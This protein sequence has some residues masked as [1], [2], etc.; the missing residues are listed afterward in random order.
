MH[1]ISIMSKQMYK[2]IENNPIAKKRYKFRKGY[3][4]LRLEQKD[5]VKKELMEKLK[6]S[7][8]P[9]FS[10]ILNNGIVD[11]TI[12]KYELISD[13]FRRY[14]ITDIWETEPYHGHCVD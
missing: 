11:I 5:E 9:Y 8:F 12:Y 13:I 4:Q 2:E 7:S 6:I 10:S 3:R 1:K 14:G